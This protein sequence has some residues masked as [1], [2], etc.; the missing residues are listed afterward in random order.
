[1]RQRVVR[2]ALAFLS[3]GVGASVH[4]AQAS[5]VKLVPSGTTDEDWL[6]HSAVD[7]DAMV[8]GSLFGD[9]AAPGSGAVH[10]YR[11]ADDGSW[12]EEAELIGNDVGSGFWF[13]KHVGIDGACIVVGAPQEWL[14]T[15]GAAYVFRHDGNSWRQEAKLLPGDMPAGGRFGAGVSVDG[16]RII[17]GAYLAQGIGQAYVYERDSGQWVERARLPSPGGVW[18]FASHSVAIRGD[19]AIA[20]SPFDPERGDGAGAAFTYR[21]A[22]G[23]WALEQK[24]VAADGVASDQFGWWADSDGNQVIVG[25]PEKGQMGAAYIF[26]RTGSTW[27]QETKLLADDAGPGDAFGY[28]CSIE[29]EWAAVGARG[30]D[31]SGLDSGAAYLFHR[32]GGLWSQHS[33]IVAPDTAS[34]DQ[35][36]FVSLDEETVTFGGL[37]N[38]NAAGINAGAIYGS[39]PS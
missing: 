4:V 8:V 10:V 5:L 39:P 9:G 21:R 3:L 19:H 16:D 14:G 17:V 33:K 28:W 13:G 7:G 18:H 27:V 24:L 32:E 22:D 34:G 25:A 30:A 1:M 15:T 12:N 20:G 36:G 31:A 2:H 11:R 29:G 6:V 37:G 38:D 35:F 26:D 23:T